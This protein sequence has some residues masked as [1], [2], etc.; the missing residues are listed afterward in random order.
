MIRISY[1]LVGLGLMWIWKNKKTGG[2][3]AGTVH[4]SKTNR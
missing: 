2:M 3:V 4:Q 1:I